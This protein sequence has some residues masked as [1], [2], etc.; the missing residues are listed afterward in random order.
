MYSQVQGFTR[1][2][3]QAASTGLSLQPAGPHKCILI[4]DDDMQIDWLFL[5][6]LLKLVLVT[7]GKFP[8]IKFRKLCILCA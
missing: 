3:M 5:S 1:N 7:F 4:I 8:N 6:F 2:L